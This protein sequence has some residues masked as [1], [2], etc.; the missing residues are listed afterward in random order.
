M[1]HQHRVT[2]EYAGH[3]L[4][5]HVRVGV[6]VDGYVL[7]PIEHDLI[8]S[9]PMLGKQGIECLPLNVVTHRRSPSAE[10]P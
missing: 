5:Q 1:A 8:A 10:T 4:S 7:N 3:F 9:L 2:P 6:E